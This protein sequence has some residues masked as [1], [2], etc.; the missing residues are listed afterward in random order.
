LKNN[1]L[2]IT[3]FFIL[4]IINIHSV[5]ADM[6]DP[7]QSRI[8]PGIIAKL[9]PQAES[10][11]APVGDPPY[12]PV[13]GREDNSTIDVNAL[14]SWRVDFLYVQNREPTKEEVEEQ[15]ASLK[16]K[17]EK[18]EIGFL[19]STYETTKAK[20]YSGDYFDIIVGLKTDGRLAGS[21]IVE[22]HEPMICPTCVPQTKLTALHETF[23][24]TNVNRRVNLNS[25]TG[26]GRGYDGVTGAT[27]SATLTTN[28][29]ITA[30]KKILRQTGLGVNE[31]PFYVD[32]DGF[33]EYSWTELV[34]WGGVVG[35]TF[36]SQ[37]IRQEL[38]PENQDYLRN[39]NKIF[40]SIYAGLANPAYVGRNIFGDKWYSYHVSQ[41]ATGDNLLVVLGSGLYSWKKNQYNRVTL[42]QKDKK[43]KFTQDEVLQA[44]ALRIKEKPNLSQIGLLR[45]PKEWGFDPL[46]KW[47][48]EFTVNEKIAKGIFSLSY[49]LPK[50]L[51][52]GDPLALEDAGLRPIKT[53]FLGLIR[54][55]KLSGWQSEWAQQDYS[56][57]FLFLLLIILTLLLI[58]QKKLSASRKIH[59]Y[60]RL[61]FLTI[62]LTWM[63]WIAQAQL[64]IVNI[65][66]YVQAL[67]QG[68]GYT[69]F[70]FEPLMCIIFVYTVVSLILLGRG[71]FCG[72][73]CP[74]GALQE[75]LFK[76]GRLIKLP[77][78]NIPFWLNERLW[79]LKYLILMLL[80]ATII[81]GNDIS[82][83]LI[84][85]EPFK[86]AIT[87]YFDRSLPYVMYAGILLAISLFTERFF[88]RFMC[89]LGA[90]LAFLGRFHIFNMI[91]RR[92]ECGSPCHLCENSCPVQAIAPSGKINMNECFQC[93]DCEV[94]YY[95]DSSCPP[96][97][98]EKKAKLKTL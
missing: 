42:G 28:G 90:V 26:G 16:K 24:G 96:L 78:I 97:I 86:T 74:F 71:V 32:V 49:D 56:I 63:G 77:Q 81:T 20:G 60:I 66:S 29:I 94:E 35:R 95:D 40:S 7:L 10:L 85:V 47:E 87:S 73:L 31:G 58:F 17:G 64:S 4:L 55:S 88:C 5:K 36:T 65:I 89:P 11:G 93:L 82:Y 34:N 72:W 41:L 57:I 25:G 30:A 62:I 13:F 48:L 18:K 39:P 22:L 70:L 1:I 2:K 59:S 8:N 98:F 6:N 9:F 83:S 43:W 38:N 15:I 12:I 50:Q 91:P 61:G 33:T 92:P 52:T 84:E 76:L 69:Q 80:T 44:T 14:H 21:V 75:I 79:V 68:K 46:E 53:A 67:V 27:I 23:K 3:I 37:E 45:I 51:I 54:E 19:F